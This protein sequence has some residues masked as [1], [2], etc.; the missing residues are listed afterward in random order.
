MCLWCCHACNLGPQPH[1]EAGQGWLA[2]TLAFL[3]GTG[4]QPD[5][6]WVLYCGDLGE[7]AHLDGGVPWETSWH[8]QQAWFD[9]ECHRDDLAGYKPSPPDTQ[10][11]QKR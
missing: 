9:P 6:G 10:D 2:E 5:G 7:H 3:A 11:D 4:A 8:Q 1:G